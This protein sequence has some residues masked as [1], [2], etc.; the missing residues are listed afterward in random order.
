MSVLDDI[1]AKVDEISTEREMSADRAFGYWFLEDIE[2][3][4]TEEAETAVVD[5]PWDGGRDAVHWDE[6]EGKLHI[7]QFKYSEDLQYTLRGFTDIQRAIQA[8]QSRLAASREVK[9]TVVTLA[10]ADDRLHNAQRSA[11]RRI[12]NWLTRHDYRIEADVVL[13]DLRK[14]AQLMERLY[15]V[16]LDLEF[17]NPPLKIDDSLLGVVNAGAFKEYVAG[18]ELFAFN[19][20]LFL[21]LREGSVNAKIK[22]TLESEDERPNFWM[23]N[24][25]ILCVCTTLEEK[26][27]KSFH[28]ENLTVV[29]G[30]QT[31][32][33]IARFLDDN[34]TV[35]E[36]IWT[37]AKIIR[38][39]EEDVDVARKLTLTSNS[40]TPTNNRDL[41]SVE[42]VHRRLARWLD[43]YYRTEYIYRRGQRRS[44]SRPNVLM[45]DMA[46]AYVSFW[47]E[48]PHVAFARPGSIFAGSTYYDTIF[49][50][51]EIDTLHSDG[52]EPEIQKFLVRRLFCT[53][54]LEVIREGVADAIR[55]GTDKMWRSIT[56]HLLWAY[57]RLLKREDVAVDQ[58]LIDR[59]P[60]L[61]AATFSPLFNGMRDTLVSSR[62]VIP[63]DLKSIQAL[64]S[65]RE[66]KF[67]ELSRFDEARTALR[68]FSGLVAS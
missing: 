23:F 63:R 17:M 48:E 37:V 19:V 61:V 55:G 5:G 2:E 32:T 60:E 42:Q 22:D 44:T 38:V 56:Y 54:L 47:L 10:S 21:G 28:F 20:R 29:N 8:E 24:N 40:Q 64:T 18:D 4:S 58:H 9:L 68:R 13:F 27:P 39:G 31:T 12:R 35:E 46:Q 25:G 11:R 43:D 33:T 3:L 15:G 59:C 66:A 14:F 1:R 49:S 16:D 57:Q 67:E 65:L 51:S 36:E 26:G 6:A 52:T 41:R 30:A 62:A 50:A 45:K 7:Y 34:P 53:R